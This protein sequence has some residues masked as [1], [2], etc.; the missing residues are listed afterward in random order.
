MP[1][2]KGRGIRVLTEDFYAV[3]GLNLWVLN[4]AGLDFFEV[5]LRSCQAAVRSF[6]GE[7]DHIVPS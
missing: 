7:L 1:R 5:E 6:A 2:R 3:A 4:L